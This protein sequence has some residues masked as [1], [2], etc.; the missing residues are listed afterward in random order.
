[1]SAPSRI[2]HCTEAIGWLTAQP[3]LQGCSIV[4]SL[5]DVSELGGVRYEEWRRW[6]HDAAALIFSRT[7]DDGAALFYQSDVKRAGAWVDKGYLVQRA[8]EQEGF[9]LLFHKIVCRVPAGTRTSGRAGYGHLMSF[10]KGLREDLS[11]ATPDVL[12]QAG[13][14]TWV[15]AIGLDA[16]RIA[17]RWVAEHTGTRTIVDPFCGVGTVLAVAN[18]VGLDAV[19]V[20][21][22]KKRAQ[23]SRGLTLA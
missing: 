8:A 1:M 6:F 18:E 7:P 15:R 21:L 3:V 14:M 4:T 2:V 23:K 12:A 19:G 11:R 9:A 22:N 10:S 13:E 5:P 16:C 17:C 20:E